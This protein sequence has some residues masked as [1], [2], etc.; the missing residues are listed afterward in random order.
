MMLSLGERKMLNNF[1]NEEQDEINAKKSRRKIFAAIATSLFVGAIISKPKNAY[2]D[3]AGGDTSATLGLWAWLKAE[4]VVITPYIKAIK[5]NY[6]LAKGY[7]DNFNT[8]VGKF[9]T[10]MTWL[11]D[12]RKFLN[13]PQENAFYLQYQQIIKYYDDIMKQ[14]NNDLLSFRLKYFHPV[15]INKIDSL[16]FQIEELYDRA[17]RIAKK[18]GYTDDKSNSNSSSNNTDGKD[19]SVT[20]KITNMFISEEE[21]DK[22]LRKTKR[23]RT[24]IRLAND[25]AKYLQASVTLQAIR[26]SVQE[27]QEKYLPDFMKKNKT[28]KNS[29]EIYN[30]MI[31]PKI[32]DAILLQTSINIETYQKFNDL[33]VMFTNQAPMV[34]DNE[35]MVT[36]EQIKNL[37]NN[38]QTNAD[39][40][41]LQSSSDKSMKSFIS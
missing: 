31:F 25:N 10:A 39:P 14:K 16:S 40:S 2:A 21:L 36:R 11:Y 41:V 33:L 26:S 34:S 24:A 3:V 12:V 23:G 1:T 7:V 6:E 19:D 5:E 29:M 28:A 38:I 17:V 13:E 4:Y 18:S 37:V 27:I 9:N 30:E 15:L 20:S 22:K 8:F 32:L 35:K